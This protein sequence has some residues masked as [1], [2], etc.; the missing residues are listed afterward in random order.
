M[1]VNFSCLAL[2]VVHCSAGTV[3]NRP[4]GIITPQS[5]GNQNK[6]TGSRP[7][8]MH[9]AFQNAGKTA[10]LEIWRVEVSQN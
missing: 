9:P 2:L 4:S 6:N 1:I 7:V 3:G 8:V 10:G 5:T